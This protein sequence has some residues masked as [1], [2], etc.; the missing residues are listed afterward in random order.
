MSRKLDSHVRLAGIM[1]FIVTLLLS[2]CGAPSAAPTT[3]APAAPA[4]SAS[5]PAASAQPSSAAPASET[6]KWGALDGLTGNIASVSV[7]AQEGAQVAVAKINAAGGIKVGGKSYK[8]ELVTYD[9]RGDPKESVAGAEKLISR[10][11]VKVIVGPSFSVATQ[12]TQEITNRDKVILLTP[13]QI[14]ESYLDKPDKKWIVKS[15]VGEAPPYGKAVFMPAYAS[16][17]LNLKSIAIASPNDE[18]GTTIAKQYKEG[19]EKAGVKVT[20]VELFDRKAADYY[21]ELTRIKATNPEALGVAYV[22]EDG[23]KWFRQAVELGITKKLVGISSMTPAAIAGIEDKITDYVISYATKNLANDTPQI[24]QFKDEYKQL[25]GRD[26]DASKFALLYYYEP[27]QML[28]KAMEKA[29]TVTDTDKIIDALR[30]SEFKGVMTY[31][32]LKDQGLLAHGFDAAHI[33]YPGGKATFSS[34][35]LGAQ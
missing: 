20:A 28:V 7:P 32:A 34:L 31:T 26:L 13:A 30:G 1:L 9:N 29:G 33:T 8:I 16:K 2:A 10:D 19:F 3:K 25:F 18:V 27:I 4:Q 21:P 5:A 6:I 15:L 35:G 24:K 23:K 17:E 22:D 14:V 12:P 11:G